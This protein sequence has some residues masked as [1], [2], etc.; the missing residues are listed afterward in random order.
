MSFIGKNNKRRPRSAY[1]TKNPAA[2]RPQPTIPISIT[3]VNAAGSVLT[4]D[5]NQSVALSGVPQYTTDVAGASPLSAELTSPTQLELT[6]SASVAA[7]TEVNIPYEDPAIRNA[8]GGFVF[9]ST[10]R[11]AA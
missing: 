11:L 4:I 7:A 9:P 3:D 10:F 8:N 5:F 1:R 6:F 2:N